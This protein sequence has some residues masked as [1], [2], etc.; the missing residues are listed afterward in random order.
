MT[1]VRRLIARLSVA[2]ALGAAALFGAGPAQTAFAG[3]GLG[4]GH[5]RVPPDTPRHGVIPPSHVDPTCYNTG[6]DG[7]DPVATGC[8]SS[9]YVATSGYISYNG[10]TYGQILNMYTTGCA[11]N[12]ARDY[13][14][15][16][17]QGMTWSAQ[18]CR[19]DVNGTCAS[20]FVSNQY[21]PY[22]YANQLG[23]LNVCVTAYGSV[24]LSYAD[25]VGSSQAC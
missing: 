20:V 15:S 23:G 24:D 21:Y 13:M 6:C 8:S 10:S 1:I 16:G 14:Y 2:A 22:M 19:P 9:A 7:T 4:P 18:T 3:A 25:A 17:T 5:Y 11:T 12:Y